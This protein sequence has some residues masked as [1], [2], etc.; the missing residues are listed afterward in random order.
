LHRH[1]G[2]RVLPPRLD[3]ERVEVAVVPVE[4]VRILEETL[5]RHREKFP[6]PLGGVVVERDETA[7]V[8]RLHESFPAVENPP[9]PLAPC[10]C[11]C[12]WRNAVDL[13]VEQVD[14][15]G[16]LVDHHASRS[17]AKPAALDHPWPGEHHAATVPGLTQTRFLPQQLTATLQRRRP[18][19]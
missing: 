1:A 4:P 16:T 13:A 3:H 11:R 7:L 8:E 18:L 2:L 12:Q 14:G 6:G 10:G 5:A 15:V 17:V 19:P 9:R